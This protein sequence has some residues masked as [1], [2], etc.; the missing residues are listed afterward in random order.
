M[1]QKELKKN[2]YFH[3][4]PSDVASIFFINTVRE[5]DKKRAGNKNGE[6][7]NY[8]NILEPVSPQN[9]DP[10]AVLE[11]IEIGELDTIQLFL[12]DALKK[13]STIQTSLTED[14]I[15]KALTV[16]EAYRSYKKTPRFNNC[17]SHLRRQRRQG[18]SAEE[19]RGR[20]AGKVFEDIGY[21]YYRPRVREGILISP[22]ITEELFLNFFEKDCKINHEYGSRTIYGVSVPDGVVIEVTNGQP[23]LTQFVEYSLSQNDEKYQNKFSAYQMSIENI[24]HRSSHAVCPNN[25]FIVNFVVPSPQWDR[26]YPNLVGSVQCVFH[27]LPFDVRNFGSQINEIIAEEFNL[28]FAARSRS[29]F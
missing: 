26:Q 23:V 18:V 21:Y 8:Y 2:G 17:L 27:I 24:R 3:G 7:N 12:V 20:F 10:N 29:R 4:G 25:E 9:V 5:Q 16:R 14:E 15:A 22:E 13:Q 11:Q 1:S 28:S 6:H 19:A